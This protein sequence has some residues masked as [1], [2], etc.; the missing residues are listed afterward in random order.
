MAQ[1]PPLPRPIG[2][3]EPWIAKA[4]ETLVLTEKVM[5]LTGDSFDIKTIGGQPIFK[6]KGRKMTVSGRKTVT[7]MHENHLF[8][9][10][11]ELLHIHTTFAAED[12]SGK[13]ILE[14]KSSFKLAGS[15]ATV[16]F[17]NFDGKDMKLKMKGNWFDTAADIVEETSG[18][19]VARIDRRL[20]NK[21][22]LL[23]G[24][25]TY[26]LTVAP[27]VDMAMMVAACVALDEKNNEK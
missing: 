11:K 3:F 19:V 27:G 16:S 20:I 2:I 8:D 23:F 13:K 6:I 18:A 12:P 25:Q 22:E 24:Q 10:V 4:S 14:V 5:S 15:K 17:K 26:A 1:L 21:R 9:I 7:D